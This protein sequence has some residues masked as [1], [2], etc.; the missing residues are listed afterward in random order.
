MLK[1][2]LL[3]LKDKNMTPALIFDIETKGD[4]FDEYDELT[5]KA[6]THWLEDK[7]KTEK[8]KEIEKIKEGLG[9]SP[10]TGEVVSIGV[11]DSESEKGAVYFQAP[12][13]EI[14]NEEDGI[15]FKSMTEEE[16]LRKF[17]EVAEKYKEF[18]TFNGRNFDVPFL[19]TRSAA[20][21]V[22]PSKDLMSNRYLGM[23]RFGSKHI[24]LLDQLTFYGAVW[25][26]KGNFHLWSRVF[27]IESPKGNGM[28]G[29]DVGKF[30]EEGKYEEIAK[31]NASD[32]IATNRL[33]KK[34]KEYYNV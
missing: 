8:E 19:M 9:L 16:M 24:D 18:V 34:W 15:K 26:K 32:I 14:E 23:Q 13:E 3:K 20:N 10:L 11:L 33:Y 7:D 12:G 31:Y 5:K 4:N 28:D 25:Q 2:K 29:S 30:F 22:K 6:L 17:W 21:E 27:G 1:S